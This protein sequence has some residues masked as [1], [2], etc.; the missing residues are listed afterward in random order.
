MKRL[1][2]TVLS[3]VPLIAMSLVSSNVLAESPEVVIDTSLGEIV[4]ELYPDKAPVTVA[5]FLNYVD[6]GAYDGSIFHRVIPGFMIQ[7]GGYRPDMSEMPEGETIHNEADNGLRNEAGTIAMARMNAI[8]SA[9]RQFFINVDDNTHLDH[10]A[11]SCTREQV[12]EV[13]AAR[14]KGLYK[15]LTCKGFGY[16]VFGRVVEGMDVVHDI[17]MVE[18]GMKQGFRDVPTRTV[19]IE[20]V[21][22][23]PSDAAGDDA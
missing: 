17:E 18:T 21:R 6:E 8:D 10:I 22:R 2:L 20:S 16:A 1:L 3:I 12:A 13:E 9:S 5:N 4:V 7:G 14:E 11:E 19:L 23:V 15:P